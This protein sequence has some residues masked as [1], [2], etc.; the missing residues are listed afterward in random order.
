MHMCVDCADICGMAAALVSCMS[1]LMAHTCMA[2][3]AIQ[4]GAPVRHYDAEGRIAA[5]GEADQRP[6]PRWGPIPRWKGASP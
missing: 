4:N 3:A 1:P 6:A 5:T 2:A